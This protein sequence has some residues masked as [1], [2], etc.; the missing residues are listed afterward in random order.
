MTPI[1]NRETKQGVYLSL[2]SGTN[3]VAAFFFQWYL[4]SKLGAGIETDAFFA[5]F[6]IPQFVIAMVGSSLMH[7]LVPILS[8]RPRERIDQDAW[9]AFWFI[10]LV[11]GLIAFIL[12]ISANLW[13]P[14]LFPGFNGHEADLTV[15]LSRIQLAGMILS[16]VNA[17]Q[18]AAYHSKQ[19]FIWAEFVPMSASIAVLPM[20]VWTLPRFGVVAGAWLTLLK[21]MLQ[22]LFLLPG[23][24]RPHPPRTSSY[25]L[26]EMRRRIAPLLVGTAYYKTDPLV[27]RALLSTALSG[28]LSL[29]YFAQQIY[30][31][32]CQVLN[33]AIAAPLV[34]KMSNFHVRKET[35]SIR[36]VYYKR[37]FIVFLLGTGCLLT[38]SLLGQ[39]LLGLLTLL[40]KFTANDITRLYWILICLGGMFIGGL[41]GQIAS[42]S[43]YACGDTKTPTKLSMVTYTLY[44]PCKVFAFLK[45]GV[46]GLA[47]VTSLYYLLN[48]FLQFHFFRRKYLHE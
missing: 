8:T 16:A 28:S 3:I 21:L 18:W 46:L 1:L 2:F 43:F 25:V 39:R 41:L 23:M 29:Y 40:G 14:M 6:T 32:V 44:I 4:L 31:A 10:G 17:V 37:L 13:V 47:T 26:R 35:S 27:E 34:P 19:K 24:G 5:S 36:K 22:T 33:K 11:F 30:G 48:F 42:V 7:V 15:T 20:L 38:V 12:I 9:I 45:N